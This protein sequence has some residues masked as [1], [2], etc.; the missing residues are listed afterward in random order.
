[1]PSAK[2]RATALRKASL[3][4]G[5]GARGLPCGL[6][7]ASPGSWLVANFSLEFSLQLQQT[8]T[9]E[10]SGLKDQLPAGTERGVY[11]SP[12]LKL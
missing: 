7:L 1:M 4:P 8:I 2:H 10:S 5:P 3:R 6:R 12:P 11:T 9:V